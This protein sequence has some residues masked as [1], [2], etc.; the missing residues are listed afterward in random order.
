MNYFPCKCV[1]FNNKLSHSV[2]FGGAHIFVSKLDLNLQFTY[3]SG[4]IFK[5][6]RNVVLVLNGTTMMSAIDS[7]IKLMLLIKN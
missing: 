2:T 1:I 6:G 5:I 7:K 4:P 3:F